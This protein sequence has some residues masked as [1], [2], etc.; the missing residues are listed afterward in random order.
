MALV[1]SP[2][3]LLFLSYPS[4]PFPSFP[5]HPFLYLSLP[6]PRQTSVD[7]VILWFSLLGHP[8]APQQ[9]HHYS[10][11]DRVSLARARSL[12]ERMVEQG[13]VTFSDAS[14]QHF[15]LLPNSLHTVQEREAQ[16]ESRGR[17]SGA[18]MASIGLCML[19]AGAIFGFLVVFCY[20]RRR[21]QSAV[22]LYVHP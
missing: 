2:P 17:Y 7:L 13:L 11:Q 12:L 18:D 6:Q 5:L 3:S 22:A 8:S 19:A 20:H 1:P 15:Q 16:A 14:G 4:L 9:N 21:R 10:M